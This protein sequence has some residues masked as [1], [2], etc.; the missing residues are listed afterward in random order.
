MGNDLSGKIV[1]DLPGVF[2]DKFGNEKE[3]VLI[4]DMVYS[5]GS[6]FNLFSLTKRLDDEWILGGNKKCIW[7]SQGNKKIVFDIK[8]VT[9]KG[10]IFAAYFKRKMRKSEKVAA[11]MADKRREITAEAAHGLVGHINDHKGRQVVQYLGFKIARKV[12]TPCGACAE[13][14]AK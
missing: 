13:A 9:P 14:K 8:I 1:G 4:K 11:V 10:A 3:N 7:I 12:M 2:C 5:P 6:E